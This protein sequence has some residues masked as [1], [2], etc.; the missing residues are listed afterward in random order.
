MKKSL[1]LFTPHAAFRIPH[2]PNRHD[3]HTRI[4][5]GGGGRNFR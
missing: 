5:L 1:R 2:S 4:K 3:R